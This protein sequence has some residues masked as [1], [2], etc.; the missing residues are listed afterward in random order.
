MKG[1]AEEHRNFVS[2][3]PKQEDFL[4]AFNAF[5]RKPIY[6]NPE[7]MKAHWHILGGTGKGKTKF[8]EHIAQTLMQR[9]E[10]VCVIDP[11]GDLY[12]ELVKY[13]TLGL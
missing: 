11:H 2:G 8:L 13:V 6:L 9:K 3:K 4:L 10:G 7:Q 12:G 1:V 5:N